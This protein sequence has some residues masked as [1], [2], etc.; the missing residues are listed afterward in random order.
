MG[1]RLSAG[2]AYA[3][4]RQMS[5]AHH[6]LEDY[7]QTKYE[8]VREVDVHSHWTGLAMLLILLGVLFDQVGFAEPRRFALAVLLVAGA[9][10]FPLGVILE[11][12]NEGSGPKALATGGAAVVIAG[13]AGVAVGFFRRR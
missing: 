5:E 6:A 1:E 9:A 2:F 10:L 3:A 4:Q 8:Y 7:A 13:L 11:T 12:V